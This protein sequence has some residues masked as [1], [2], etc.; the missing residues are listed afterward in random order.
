MKIVFFNPMWNNIS[1]YKRLHLLYRKIW[2]FLMCVYEKNIL[3]FVRHW[4][5]ESISFEI[6]KVIS[7]VR[8]RSSHGFYSRKLWKR[9][10]FHPRECIGHHWNFAFRPAKKIYVLLSWFQSILL[11][12]D[13]SSF[14]IHYRKQIFFWFIGLNRAVIISVVRR[15]ENRSRIDERNYCRKSNAIETRRSVQHNFVKKPDR[16][17]CDSAISTNMVK[18]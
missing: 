9:I 4:I 11:I 7:F 6:G 2:F 12:I 15:D 1:L 5:H 16:G 13:S 14:S 3:S 18:G 8:N 10:L 17:F